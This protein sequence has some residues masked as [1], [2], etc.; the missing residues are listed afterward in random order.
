ML[1]D[2]E[3]ESLH[4]VADTTGA[5]LL[6]LQDRN[7]LEYIWQREKAVWGRSA[8]VLFPIVGALR[9]GCTVIDGESCRIERHGSCKDAE[10]RLLSSKADRAVFELDDAGYA[11][12]G[13][14][15]HC[16]LRIGFQLCGR[17]LQMRAQ[18][19]NRDSREVFYCIGLHPG[20]RCPL[21]AGESFEDYCLTFS[22]RETEGYRQYDAVKQ[23]FDRSRELFLPEIGTGAEDSRGTEA[24]VESQSTRREKA[25]GRRIE[26]EAKR[27][28]DWS[29]DRVSESSGKISDA[30]QHL[31]LR[32]EL[33]ANDAIWF[34]RLRS[35]SVKLLNRERTAG[36]WVSF[37]DF[38]TLG[39][40][41]LPEEAAKF[42]C[43]EPWNGSAPCSDEDDQFLHKN[44]LQ[45]LLPG[46]SR[47]YAMEIEPLSYS[48]R[49][50]AEPCGV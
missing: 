1:V 19:L 31:Q 21:F 6:S 9:G 47:T 23:E 15:Y 29:V 3:N 8:P 13:Y 44:H 7:G 28:T 41:T 27:A 42:L 26:Q 37:P 20:F 50:E 35:R 14:P 10:F 22:E 24:V 40:W 39:L 43:I 5:Q 36:V 34:D 25:V 17:R 48:G 38:E 4:A 45:Q 12:G 18:V 2:L 11:P 46:E 16:T 30:M 32:R 33:F 49:Q